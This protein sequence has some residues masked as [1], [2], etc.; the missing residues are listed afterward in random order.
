MEISRTDANKY[1]QELLNIKTELTTKRI[2]EPFSDK[3]AAYLTSDLLS[4]VFTK[5][6]VLGLFHKEEVNAVRIYL[7][8]KPDTG[9]PSLV[10]IPC[11]V[12]QNQY[13][14]NQL[15]S[16]QSA[17]RQYPEPTLSYQKTEGFDVG[18]DAAG[19]DNTSNNAYQTT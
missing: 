15:Q 13:V 12:D 17:G 3:A 10:L 1:I 2:F 9:I 8:A 14:E 18:N 16:D 5:E 7:A 6:E 11:S 4:F 19:P